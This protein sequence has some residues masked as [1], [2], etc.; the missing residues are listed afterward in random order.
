MDVE[1]I[2]KYKLKGKYKFMFDLKEKQKC[3]IT[4]VME[5]KNSIGIFPTG[6]GKSV[7]FQM[8]P[9]IH[10]AIYGGKHIGLVISSLKSLMIYQCQQT[11][12]LGISSVCNIKKDEMENH[13]IEG[14]SNY[15]KSD[16]L[17]LLK[18][19]KKNC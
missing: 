18:L 10:D 6:Y 12:K 11:Q 13:E 1:T 5:R 7:C 4:N 19:E 3:L 17:S 15:L 2:Y 9:L 16:S 8:V 14:I